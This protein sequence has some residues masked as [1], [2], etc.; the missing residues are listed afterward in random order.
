MF[1]IIA[2]I[3]RYRLIVVFLLL[4]IFSFTLIVSSNQYAAGWYFNFSSRWSGAIGSISNSITDYL[5]LK[6][7]NACLSAQNARLME[8]SNA[9][10]FSNDSVASSFDQQQFHYIP[11]KVVSNS[12]NKRNN[13][14]LIN[15]GSQANI[16]KNMGVIGPDGVV[17][18][19]IGVSDHFSVVMSL[20]HKSSNISGKILPDNIIG[21][22]TWDGSDFRKASLSNIPEHYKIHSGE[23]VVTSGYSLLFPEGINIGIIHGFKLSDDAHLYQ[24]Q[25]DLS[26]DFQ[27]LKWVYIVDNKLLEE[28]ETLLETSMIDE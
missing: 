26:T 14:L 15:K 16:R 23:E 20:L 11:A 4:E 25:L 3:K 22:V 1:Q 5:N 19:V 12:I 8:Q 13:Y 10:S 6:T 17:G 18:I 24:I 27:S 7:V 2:F 28:Q 21:S 9:A